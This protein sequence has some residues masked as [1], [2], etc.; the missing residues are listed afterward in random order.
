MFRIKTGL[1]PMVKKS[2]RDISFDVSYKVTEKASEAHTD[3]NY[4]KYS[5]LERISF[6]VG[7]IDLELELMF[8]PRYLSALV[9]EL[10]S[11]LKPW[12]D[13]LN[14]DLNELIM[15]ID[16]TE[17]ING[18]IQKHFAKGRE[19]AKRVSQVYEQL[20]M[21]LD[22]EVSERIAAAIKIMSFVL[23]AMGKSMRSVATIKTF[24]T[25]SAHFNG[26]MCLFQPCIESVAVEM[27]PQPTETPWKGSCYDPSKTSFQIW[28]TKVS[29][30]S[31][32]RAGSFFTFE[33]GD[34]FNLCLS[35][36]GVNKGKFSGNFNILG[37]SNRLGFVYANGK[38]DLPVFTVNINSKYKFL[39]N[40]SVG[41]VLNRWDMMSATVYGTAGPRSKI[42]AELQ[43]SVDTVSLNYFEKFEQRRKNSISKLERLANEKSPLRGK[44]HHHQ[45]QLK[46]ADDSYAHATRIY[47]SR[48]AQYNAKLR[49]FAQKRD[50][51]VS[52]ERQLDAV[53]TVK[54][55][56]LQCHRIDNCT[57]CQNSITVEKT[58]PKCRR[59]YDNR[60]YT[61][62]DNF[63]STCSHFVEDRRRK[64]T[65]NCKEPPIGDIRAKEIID[66]LNRK[67]KSKI[68]F[69]LED[70]W[71]LRMINEAQG[72]ELEGAV[73]KQIFWRS[74][75]GKLGN[76]TL[77]E[78]DFNKI[79]QYT[80]STFAEKIR[81]K[82][83]KIKLTYLW[84]ELSA[85]LNKSGGR[86][87]D[88]D[89][90]RIRALDETFATKL[91]TRLGLNEKLK[92]GAPLNKEELKLFERL[93]PKSYGVFIKSTKQMEEKKKIV[94][95]I[96]ENIKKGT[97]SAS[98]LKEL[99]KIDPKAAKSIEEGLKEQ[100][101][102]KLKEMKA[103]LNG[104]S[105]SIV[106][107]DKENTFG[108][109][110]EKLS[111]MTKNLKPY[112]KNQL[113]ELQD[114]IKSAVAEKGSVFDKV[115]ER[116]DLALELRLLTGVSSEFF[117]SLDAFSSALDKFDLHEIF[118]QRENRIVQHLGDL[119]K[120][121]ES[122]GSLF[123]KLCKK[124]KQNCSNGRIV[125]KTMLK[126][127]ETIG[128]FHAKVCGR[129]RMVDADELCSSLNKVMAFSQRYDLMKSR[130]CTEVIQKVVP[131]IRNIVKEI[132]NLGR[133]DSVMFEKAWKTS[134]GTVSIRNDYNAVV[135]DFKKS[136]SSASVTVNLPAPDFSIITACVGKIGRP[137]LYSVKEMEYLV[138]REALEAFKDAIKL[139]PIDKKQMFSKRV[140]IP[141]EKQASLKGYFQQLVNG[142]T[143]SLL[144]I[145]S[146]EAGKG[147][148]RAAI[149]KRITRVLSV[150]KDLFAKMLKE[151]D[152]L[153]FFRGS[154]TVSAT[155]EHAL[156]LANEVQ[157]MGH[158]CANVTKSPLREL[159]AF[160]SEIRDYTAKSVQD[161]ATDIRNKFRDVGAD[162][163]API[164]KLMDLVD[165]MVANSP[166]FDVPVILSM[167][168]R[169]ARLLLSSMKRYLKM[170]GEVFKKFIRIK[171]KCRGCRIEEVLGAN[172][173]K[174]IAE[175]LDKKLKPVAAKVDK[176]ISD[177]GFA[178]KGTALFFTSLE[179]IRT[180]LE[181]IA[182][183]E[184]TY[185]EK[186]FL[187]IVD[188]V[189]Y[190][191][192]AIEMMEK[193]QSA[194]HIK[195]S[196]DGNS[197]IR[198]FI[199]E[200]SKLKS[201]VA[202]LHE[203]KKG[204]RLEKA[205]GKMDKILSSIPA[206]GKKVES[207]GKGTVNQLMDTL[208]EMG[209]TI[210]D[211]AH[212]AS[213]LYQSPVSAYI[214]NDWVPKVAES[215]DMIERA[216][217]TLIPSTERLLL[218]LGIL[219][220]KH[221][222]K[223]RVLKMRSYARV[224]QNVRDSA[225]SRKSRKAA[226]I[227]LQSQSDE[228]HLKRIT[229]YWRGVYRK[230][231]GKIDRVKS[232][233]LELR[234]KFEKYMDMYKDIKNTVEEI[235]KGP[236]AEIGHVK[237][238][239]E[240][241]IGS[242]KSY[243]LKKLLISNPKIFKAKM[244][245][246]RHLFR[247]S[248]TA[249]NKVD[250][251]LKDCKSCSVESVLGYRYIK[252]L[253]KRVEKS[254]SS[255]FEFLKDFDN[256]VAEGVKE[257]RSVREAVLPLKDRFGKIA[258]G[259]KNAAVSLAEFGKA[260]A[261]SGKDLDA[262]Q[263]SIERFGEVLLGRD[264]ELQ[265]LT[266]NVKKIANKLSAVANK[267]AEVASN[268]GDA[269]AEVKKVE[270]IL[271]RIHDGKEGI[272]K[273]PVQTRISVAK[274]ASQGIKAAIHALPRVLQSS[275]KVLASA[276]IDGDWLD[277]FESG[278]MAA[279]TNVEKLRTK[280]DKVLNAAGVI[281]QGKND[282]SKSLEALKRNLNDFR[283]SPFTEKIAAAKG[284]S[285][286]FD[287]FVDET[288]EAV[289]ASSTELGATLSKEGLV[290]SIHDLI[291]KERLANISRLGGKVSSALNKIQKDS[292][293]EVGK[294][295][296]QV[297][298]YVDGLKDFD[299]KEALL[300]NPTVL[301]EKI[302]EFQGL[303]DKGGDLLLSIADITGACKSCSLEDILGNGFVSKLT[304][305]VG[306]TLDE[307]YHGVKDISKRIKTGRKGLQ[308]FLN[309]AKDISERFH[310]VLRDGKVTSNAI[311]SAADGLKQSAARL[312][313]LKGASRDIFMAIFNDENEV[314]KMQESFTKIIDTVS[315]KAEK[316]G[317]LAEKIEKAYA[318]VEDIKTTTSAISVDL[319]KLGKSPLELKTQI[320]R[321]ML[322]HVQD[323]FR[324]VPKVLQQSANVGS[325]L[326]GDAQWIDNLG[327]EIVSFNEKATLIFNK[328][329][330]MLKSAGL[331]A[332]GVSYIGSASKE[333]IDDVE[334]MRSL[335]VSE[336]IESFKSIARKVDDVMDH[337]MKAASTFESAV[338]SLTG[339]SINISEG[340]G[341]FGDSVSGIMLN[342]TK[343][344][345][346]AERLYTDITDT[347]RQIEKGPV[348]KVGALTDSIEDFVG[349]L[350]NY[351]LAEVLVQAPKFS[352]EKIG[353]L[354][355]IIKDSGKM[356]SNVNAMLGKHCPACDINDVF[357]KEFSVKVGD[358]IRKGFDRI[359]RN[360]TIFLDK[361]AETGENVAGMTN[362]VKEI[363]T[364]VKS[365]RGIKFDSD[366]LRKASS[367]LSKTS[368]L[369]GGIGKDSQKLAGVLFEENK[370]LNKLTS[371]FQGLVGFVGGFMNSTGNVLKGMTGAMDKVGKIR[372]SFDAVR[373]GF[374]GVDKG[375]LESR[376]K[377]VEDVANG[378]VELVSGVPELAESLGASKQFGTFVRGFGS[379]LNEVANGISGIVAKTQDL[380]GDV[381]ETVQSVGK[382]AQISGHIGKSFNRVL[383]SP[384]SGKLTAL[385]D[386]VN[387]VKELTGE[388]NSATGTLSDVVNKVTGMSTLK[389]PI[390][391]QT[392]E[393]VLTDISGAVNL[394]AD[395]F[396]KYQS[397][398]KTVDK[399]FQSASADPIGFAVNDLPKLITQT[400][401]LVSTMLNDTKAIAAKLGLKL[402]G[403]NLNPKLVSAS[404]EFF[405]F[406]K[407]T[408][409]TIQSGK[410]LF[411]N[412]KDLFTSKDFV[413]GMKNFQDVVQNGKKFIKNLDSLGKQ[414]FKQDWSG[415][416]GDFQ[417]TLNKIGDSVGINFA[418]TGKIF[419]KISGSVTSVLSIV[420]DVK[421]LLSIKD[422]NVETLIQ[423]TKSVINIAQSTVSLLNR[424][425]A[426]IQTKA[427]E[428]IGNYA[429]MALAVFQIGKG[430]FD[431]V[432]WVNDVCDITY[433]TEANQKELTYR[434]IKGRLSTMVVNIPVVNCDYVAKNITR[435]YG[436]AGFCCNGTRCLYIQ[437]PICLRENS[438]CAQKRMVFARRSKSLNREIAA[439]YVQYET[440][441]QRMEV[442]QIDM[443]TAEIT[444]QRHSMA[445]NV[446]L[447]AWKFNSVQA[448][449][450][451]QNLASINR[452]L[453]NMRRVVNLAAKTSRIRFI[454]AE[455]NT[456]LY[457][458]EVLRLPFKV[459]LRDHTGLHKIMR[460]MMDFQKEKLSI[461]QFTEY[462][463]RNLTEYRVSRKRRSASN[464]DKV[465]E[466]E[467]VSTCAELKSRLSFLAKLTEKLRGRIGNL[468][469]NSFHSATRTSNVRMSS[470]AFLAM[471]QLL[472]S[473]RQLDF[474]SRPRFVN[475]LKEWREEA[476]EWM[477]MTYK[478]K[479]FDLKD[480]LEIMVENIQRRMDLSRRT[481]FRLISNL[482][483]TVT[484][485]IGV[486]YSRRLIKSHILKRLM[487]VE[488]D[489]KKINEQAPICHKPPS[490]DTQ[491]P[492]SLT[493]YA[494]E[495]LALTCKVHASGT[496]QYQWYLN[497]TVL[498]AFRERVLR[499]KSVT[500]DYEGSYHCRVDTESGAVESNPV[501]VLL[502]KRMRFLEQLESIS[503]PNTGAREARLVCNT[504]AEEDASYSWWYQSF[505]GSIRKLRSHSLALDIG[506]G[507]TGMSGIFWCEV[508]NGHMKLRSR[509]VVVALVDSKRRSHITRFDLPGAFS[510]RDCHLPKAGHLI[511]NAL[512]GLIV[513][514]QETA[515]Y[516]SRVTLESSLSSNL[517]PGRISISLE[518]QPRGNQ[519]ATDL[520]LASADALTQYRVQKMASSFISGKETL[521]INSSACK[522]TLMKSDARVELN[523][524]ERKCPPGMGLI[525]SRLRC[526]E[527]FMNIE[528]TSHLVN[529][530]F[531][532]DFP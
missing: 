49:L 406:A 310:N 163:K 10:R 234:R 386:M 132:K 292:I 427:F 285:R 415:I 469:D 502:R 109:L 425:G 104:V 249:I 134:K 107:G 138:A 259:E 273:G 335:P 353:E 3:S 297:D 41:T 526:G 157:R 191:I 529:M 212:I 324:S 265:L 239:L 87:Y 374:H 7:D 328:T 301:Q 154:K 408:L 196:G 68:P 80:N 487:E 262:M 470:N 1:R 278:L 471:R 152:L 388:V 405:S 347:V 83:K 177:L 480:C 421:S 84:E 331:L 142:L 208:Q 53:C 482:K 100:L 381:R 467:S 276:G 462:L 105:N 321:R 495:A 64:Y 127:R 213:D 500:R 466:S 57:V 428:S 34:E 323:I 412:F 110:N 181:S 367:V 479:C 463:L 91:K 352:K 409:G 417:K 383:D 382:I 170:V 164:G 476:E 436:K 494:G 171:G 280:T 98:D 81:D 102:R 434:C 289:A 339:A 512:H 317:I 229:S 330:S 491:L 433:V 90:E 305:D 366:G 140:L 253:A 33:T 201:Y 407:N 114:R 210:N 395:R 325:F 221:G 246:L 55:C 137:G 420:S 349:A 394:V 468:A 430:I 238:S 248:A 220:D 484:T 531:E 498:P 108:K 375:P 151:R 111:D 380:A 326:G 441:R 523:P 119:H 340:I 17:R 370:E 520:N 334:L 178:F 442:A 32:Q 76:A 147:E 235:K 116:F 290:E 376:L 270:R 426:N 517:N 205:I 75:P 418:K 503:I 2:S 390:F 215:L 344:I 368:N 416:K 73:R 279:A 437:N 59:A 516:R 457:S 243:D 364:Q 333:I 393:K 118:L 435:G 518:L 15:D 31:K 465:V 231:A 288:L 369:I 42:V 82:Q 97:L 345:N 124:C 202:E 320:A 63:D 454:K 155:L 287:A 261:E 11:K 74:F 264:V 452:D 65:G 69:T 445:H 359:T 58:V 401:S 451:R 85:K 179:Q 361:V 26:S 377:A 365:L 223:S 371:K 296:D 8:P 254:F 247:A 180:D 460:F 185:N 184:S 432:G 284:V 508:S 354:K 195:L 497:K 327:S 103:K 519:R 489:L 313:S 38:I 318:T 524:P 182:S 306:M 513:K 322:S 40:S 233:M 342:V 209:S 232:H 78:S 348:A 379:K 281:V 472:Q 283:D 444:K 392:T 218:H 528:N 449:E 245:E 165:E 71:N 50:A 294:L 20:K 120:W 133:A 431:F 197:E 240:E 490:L 450:T 173:L 77:G 266:N 257:F 256:K 129:T 252:D 45:E 298:N 275:K 357:G 92:S 429:N 411:G 332:K 346:Y 422:L 329:D 123:E 39:V 44:M 505:S 481:D 13:S 12:L 501:F 237:D 130:G 402:E 504:T 54:T 135:N 244:Q 300:S 314:I 295:T 475:V 115:S 150:A 99:E 250:D 141:K 225:G 396:E 391:G 62:K 360:L 511:G 515:G 144:K 18:M 251:L 36:Y 200:L 14:V 16:N 423:A 299:V 455:F 271:D 86:L 362:S 47:K 51:F 227:A 136:L 336:K 216:K 274:E 226:R 88:D 477:I 311:K 149:D 176:F 66:E 21:S 61:F 146:D 24:D 309:A 48:E 355:A 439:A 162:V 117:R 337:T 161:V 175:K 260:F 219:T 198:I 192:D 459:I 532:D 403:L 106:V 188:G 485:L 446:S 122:L 453:M 302:G 293:P 397:L 509:K 94:S 143:K 190:A 282:I 139:L 79:K 52:M 95:R 499:L 312:Q 303:A 363:E 488:S 128:K 414:L 507:R 27:R 277:T 447:A 206:A 230:V 483:L 258:K 60:T 121:F 113:R 5:Q 217:I 522:L 492:T 316:G 521:H 527:C 351:D 268:V 263:G 286:A 514:G 272:K 443:Q 56:Y 30:L 19:I 304:K 37:E 203:K 456:V 222:S 267:S 148:I 410:E 125:G 496:M 356:L 145:C 35:V 159:D 25:L 228:T 96:S 169:E 486:S 387:Q 384:F 183:S 400:D 199:K 204:P 358:G 189:K 399:A 168:Q 9:K 448:E 29:L 211:L 419:D 160:L 22:L 438:L 112:D 506:A 525:K 207:L 174:S 93:D 46:A 424:F 186:T 308:P 101:K 440:A 193:G 338:E 172:S 478:Q 255:Y 236:M 385:K 72:M 389:S 224:F 398:T 28:S 194:F 373:K 413:G 530:L 156:G 493:A 319:K 67:Q 378:L 242:V 341:K 131:F 291:G 43:K 307:L 214:E 70:A 6:A 167:G 153:S 474:G 315:D 187:D 343:G 126:I 464:E 23:A 510:G 89:I 350:K 269:Y 404:N 241:L 158:R 372:D 458:S 166:S 473:I 4:N 461:Q